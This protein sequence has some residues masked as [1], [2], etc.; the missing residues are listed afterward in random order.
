MY[1]YELFLLDPVQGKLLDIPIL[2][3]NI[4]TANDGT[5]NGSKD[6]TKYVLTRRFF[7]ID[8]LSGIQGPGNF[9]NNVTSTSV[10][11]FAQTI[12]FNV[13][14][15][16]NDTA[17]ITTP[18]LQITYQSRHVDSLSLSP[19]AKILFQSMYYMDLASFN[20]KIQAFFITL[21]VLVGL[22][23]SVKMYIWTKNNPSEL[24]PVQSN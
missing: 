12:S 2:I 9:F 15:L 13:K 20:Y 18:Y 3:T 7:I 22:V 24:S 10:I 23:V 21:N 11:R 6:S 16:A 14:L 17:R 19:S 4:K 8:N 1:F 5:P